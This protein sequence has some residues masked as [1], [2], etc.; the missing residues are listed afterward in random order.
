MRLVSPLLKRVVYPTLSRIGYLHLYAERS[1]LSVVT[2][3]G[4]LPTGYKVTD[5]Q[6][7]GSWISPE[8]FRQ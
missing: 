1:Q 2:Y 8:V 5:L 7:D 6:L 4:A 3:H